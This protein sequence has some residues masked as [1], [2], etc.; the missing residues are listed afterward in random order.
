MREQIR[1]SIIY[2]FIKDK[3]PLKL[4]EKNKKENIL[5]DEY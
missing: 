2:Y 1:K 3:K 4:S 5:F